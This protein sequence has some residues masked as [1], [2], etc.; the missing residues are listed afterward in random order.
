MK[1]PPYKVGK[2]GEQIAVEH[3]LKEGYRIVDR[4]FRVPGGE[5]DIVARDEGVL[6]FIEVKNYSYR[7]FYLPMY[8]ISKKKRMRLFRTAEEYLYRKDIINNDCR[9][10]IILI[11]RSESG[12]RKVELIKN[13]FM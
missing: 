1:E 6:V 11:Y 3:L 9:F 8:S 4:N 2:I 10:D 7:N 12:K 5:I 13:A